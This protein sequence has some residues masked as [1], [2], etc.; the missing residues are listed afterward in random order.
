[1]IHCI[2][3]VE[4]ITDYLEDRMPPQERARFDEHLT[5]CDGC[6]MYLEQMRA[7]LAAIGHIP[8]ESVS[9][10]ARERLLQSFRD[11]KETW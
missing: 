9:D 4:I 11:W 1:M 2:E 3:L 7:S 8:R 6:A 10:D 5:Y